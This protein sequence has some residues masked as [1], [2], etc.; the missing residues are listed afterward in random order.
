MAD[1]KLHIWEMLRYCK[2]DFDNSLY[3]YLND[4]RLYKETIHSGKEYVDILPSKSST[5]SGK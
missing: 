1:V 4:W 2:Q 3:E 5:N